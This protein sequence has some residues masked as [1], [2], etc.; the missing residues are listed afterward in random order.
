MKLDEYFQDTGNTWISQEDYDFLIEPSGEKLVKRVKKGVVYLTTPLFHHMEND[1]SVRV[2]DKLLEEHPVFPKE[3]I[4]F[5]LDWFESLNQMKLAQEQREAVYMGI[6]NTI[7]VLTGGPGTG[8]TCVLNA[9]DFISRQLGRE[10]LLYCAP[11][12][13]AARRITESTGRPAKTTQKQIS[14]NPATHEVRNV[15]ADA[16]INDEVSIID[17]ETMYHFMRAV[18]KG[19]HLL[20]VGDVE[21]LPSVGPGAV[22]RDLIDS[23][24]L[25]VTKLE[26]TFRQAS[27]SGILTNI[28]KIKRGQADLVEMEDFQFL[29]CNSQEAQKRLIDTYLENLKVY[30]KDNVIILTPYR[31]KGDTCSNELNKKIQQLVNPI[32]TKSFVKAN[33]IEEGDTTPRTVIFQV[34]DPVMQLINRQEC[35]N[36]DVGEVIQASDNGVMVQYID[37]KV[38]YPISELGQITLAYAMSIHKSQGSEY[39]CVITPILDEHIDMLNRN[40][41]YTAVTRAKKI[42]IMM[43]KKEL[44]KEALVKEAGYERVTGLA[45]E[46]FMELKKRVL[47]RQARCA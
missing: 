4:D 27:D 47:L 38:F 3:E 24:V 10:I 21:Q 5:Y 36:G 31:R 33:V 34:G 12:G 2:I 43:G 28:K 13:K 8:K 44:I 37:G 29:P 46:I 6:N 23:K 19:T 30:G 25:P 20:F 42:C 45:E 26:E 40:I 16:I 7:S 18:N 11:T 9:L 39:P 22:L 41:I 17:M 32:G 15:S 1:I 14:L 35:A